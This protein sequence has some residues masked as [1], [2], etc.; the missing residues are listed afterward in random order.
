M[1][2]A[3]A[4]LPLLATFSSATYAPKKDAYDIIFEDYF[5]GFQL[6]PPDEKQWSILGGYQGVLGGV[7]SWYDPTMKA[8]HLSGLSTV[9]LFSWQN[10]SN[11]N[12]ITGGIRSKLFFDVKEGRTTTVEA[13]I[14]HGTSA[15]EQKHGICS[16]FTIVGECGTQEHFNP[17]MCGKIH[18]MSRRDFEARS[19]AEARRQGLFV[20]DT[21]LTR[22]EIMSSELI[23]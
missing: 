8:L 9:K 19:Y 13:R 10:G 14:R 2:L 6:M 4:I 11:T 21:Y 20:S 23:F 16:F 17:S 5:Q 7:E 1:R 18:V 3:T 12:W 22:R 15:P